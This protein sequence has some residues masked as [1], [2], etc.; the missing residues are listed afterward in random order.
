VDTRIEAKLNNQ[1]LGYFIDLKDKTLIIS[2]NQYVIMKLKWQGS[3]QQAQFTGMKGSR[4]SSN[5]RAYV[6]SDNDRMHTDLNQDGHPEDFMASPRSL[7]APP[8]VPLQ[9]HQA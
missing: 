1:T 3:Y 6:L 7:S 8:K 5:Q 2:F 9:K 4:D